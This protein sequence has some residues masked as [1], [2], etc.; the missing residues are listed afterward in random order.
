MEC[1]SMGQNLLCVAQAFLSV[2]WGVWAL[3]ANTVLS[4]GVGGMAAWCWCN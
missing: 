1:W 4:A 3:I 2:D